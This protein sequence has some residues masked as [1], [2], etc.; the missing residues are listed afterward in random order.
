MIYTESGVLEYVL[1]LTFVL[2]YC[3]HCFWYVL[4]VL[5]YAFATTLVVVHALVLI[6]IV[7]D[8]GTTQ[9]MR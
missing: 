8:T 6:C 2:V 9:Y 4:Y 1:I 3:L 7:H 5:V